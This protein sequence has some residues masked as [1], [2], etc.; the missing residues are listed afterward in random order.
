[1]S[2]RLH[3]LTR[4]GSVALLGSAAAWGCADK[5]APTPASTSA[6]TAAST[7]A[8][9]SGSAAVTVPAADAAAP[10]PP[11]PTQSFDGPPSG[12]VALE[13]TP[14]SW[15]KQHLAMRAPKGWTKGVVQGYPTV[16]ADNGKAFV[17]LFGDVGALPP[18]SHLDMRVKWLDG[19]AVNWGRSGDGKVGPEHLKAELREGPGKVVETVDGKPVG[20]EAHFWA[21]YFE[22]PGRAEGLLVLAAAR[23]DAPERFAEVVAMI[24]SITAK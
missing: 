6:A 10:E 18:G 13:T 3:D 7:P 24:Q 20:R 2:S 16:R 8:V 12:E 14:L 19:F 11:G 9:A 1:M 15:P 4:I 21:V 22:P 17:A 23:A 5:P